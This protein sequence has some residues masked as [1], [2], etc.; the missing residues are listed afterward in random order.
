MSRQICQSI[1]SL[2]VDLAVPSDFLHIPTPWHNS[3]LRMGGDRRWYIVKSKLVT[4]ALRA[5]THTGHFLH[6]TATSGGY[7][8]LERSTG[9]AMVE[10]RA[11]SIT[12]KP[13]PT[14]LGP[15]NTTGSTSDTRAAWLSIPFAR[16]LSGPPKKLEQELRKWAVCA[17]PL[18]G[19]VAVAL[20]RLYVD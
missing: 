20:F 10:T 17:F 9:E 12:G 18:A 19:M 15:S 14:M 13:N 5:Q 3:V 16:S 4:D 2:A 6:G 11:A 1:E 8:Q 7:Y